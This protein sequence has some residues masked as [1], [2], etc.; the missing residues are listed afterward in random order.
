MPGIDVLEKEEKYLST[1]FKITRNIFFALGTNRDQA[2]VQFKQGITPT[3]EFDFVD[4]PPKHTPRNVYLGRT[5]ERWGGSGGGTNSARGMKSLQEDE[6]DVARLKAKLAQQTEDNK[7]IEDKPEEVQKRIQSTLAQPGVTFSKLPRFG[8]ESY[9][10][11][12][13][14]SSR[15]NSARVMNTNQQNGVGDMFHGLIGGNNNNNNNSPGT[16]RGGGDSML[17][18]GRTTS[19]RMTRKT[20]RELVTEA[21]KENEIAAQRAAALHPTKFVKKEIQE[22]KKQVAEMCLRPT[23]GPP[24]PR[25]VSASST[26]RSPPQMNQQQHQSSTENNNNNNMIS[27]STLPMP[28]G[29]KKACEFVLPWEVKKKEKKKVRVLD[30]A[31]ME[32]NNNN[33]N[34]LAFSSNPLLVSDEENRD[35][36]EQEWRAERDRILDS[37]GLLG[38]RSMESAKR[39]SGVHP[40]PTTLVNLAK[41]VSRE[42]A[43]SCHA[44]TKESH[45]LLYVTNDDVIRRHRNQADIRFEKFANRHTDVKPFFHVPD[46]LLKTDHLLRTHKAMVNRERNNF[47]RLLNDA[48]EQELNLIAEETA[49][50]KA[51]KKARQEII[52]AAAGKKVEEMFGKKKLSIRIL[53]ENEKEN[54]K[55]NVDNDEDD[56]EDD[57]QVDPIKKARAEAAKAFLRQFQPPDSVDIPGLPISAADDARFND[58]FTTTTRARP[59]T[60]GESIITRK[61]KGAPNLGSY[62]D[63]PDVPISALF[64]GNYAAVRRQAEKEVDAE[65]EK[66]HNKSAFPSAFALS[67]KRRASSSY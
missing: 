10:G 28:E 44:P 55:R 7:P 4:K 30:T 37:F 32:E 42:K 3:S 34:H 48:T 17:S 35:K 65:L 16:D 31:A 23:F 60:S 40:Q 6:A 33:N 41:Q 61:F 26:A 66:V 22:R 20:E 56:D 64:A 24:P 29:M 67:M 21:E 19:A 38:N 1:R 12:G 53:G 39:K 52:A 45:D 14:V 2:N 47:V 49:K 54:N 36:A 46:D 5:Q 43:W 62:A 13:R 18:T 25:P 11:E 57:D 51:A 50:K 58:G 63:R 15:P 8:N 9:P 27:S 59:K